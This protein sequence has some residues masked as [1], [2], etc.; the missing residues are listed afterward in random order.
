M[1]GW[2]IIDYKR[3]V[4]APELLFFRYRPPADVTV[5][6]EESAVTSW[7]EI[8]S[9]FVLKISTDTS[10]FICLNR[11]A[12]CRDI[13]RSRGSIIGR[14]KWYKNVIQFSRKQTV[15]VGM[16]VQ[17]DTTFMKVGP[18]VFVSIIQRCHIY[19]LIIYIPHNHTFRSREC[20]G[21]LE[22]SGLISGLKKQLRELNLIKNK[23]GIKR[24]SRWSMFETIMQISNSM[25]LRDKK[26]VKD[27]VS[28]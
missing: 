15:A 23:L 22:L 17:S 8:T 25:K 27:M 1:C 26:K 12:S 2:V 18:G 7:S 16:I 28:P 14:T 6:L 4:L 3:L 5:R 21:G 19:L 11:S 13:Q 24:S 9:L 10:G 20:V